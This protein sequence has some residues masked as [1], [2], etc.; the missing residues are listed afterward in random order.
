MVLPLV[1]QQVSL[2]WR[3]D[4]PPKRDDIVARYLRLREISKKL[5]NEVLHSI[6]SDVLLNH[7]RAV[8]DAV[9]ALGGFQGDR[10]CGTLIS[11]WIKGMEM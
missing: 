4:V 1:Q 7:A 3:G 6:S 8:G 2:P 11:I 10:A 9:K 5:H